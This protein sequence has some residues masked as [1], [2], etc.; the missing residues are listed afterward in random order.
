M[1]RPRTAAAFIRANMPLSA[2]GTLTDQ[3][4]LDVAAYID[5]AVRPD[6]AAKA[7]DWPNG[8]PPADLP[9]GTRAG[10]RTR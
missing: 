10:R 2:P 7:D 3:Q 5:A 4:A 1:A 9:Y 6:F 8:D